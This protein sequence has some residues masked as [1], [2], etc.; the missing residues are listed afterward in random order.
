M[1]CTCLV[2]LELRRG[3]ASFTDFNLPRIYEEQYFAVWIVYG[4]LGYFAFFDLSS[5]ISPLQL[6]RKMS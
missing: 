1:H 5:V 6:G 4:R 2:Q 3:A